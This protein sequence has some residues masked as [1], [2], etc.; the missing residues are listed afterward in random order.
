MFNLKFKNYLDQIILLSGNFKN[1]LKG[2]LNL[3][4][5]LEVIDMY[6]VPATD[7][8]DGLMSAED[9]SNLDIINARPTL[10]VQNDNSVFNDISSIVLPG[11]KISTTGLREVTIESLMSNN[12]VYVGSQYMTSHTIVHNL[13]SIDL[14]VNIKTKEIEDLYYRTTYADVQFI[15]NNTIVVNFVRAESPRILIST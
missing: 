10:S 15:N 14:N 2:T 5:A 3:K 4:N 6:L 1:A 7:S 8:T 12:F 13:N 11:A 9:K